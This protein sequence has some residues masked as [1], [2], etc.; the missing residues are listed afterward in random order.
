M[1]PISLASYYLKSYTLQSWLEFLIIVIQ[2]TIG[3][4]YITLLQ[5]SKY[6]AALGVMVMKFKIYD[7]TMNK[8]GF[9]RLSGRHWSTIMSVFTLW[10]TS[11]MI[12]WTKR[13]QGLHD[14]AART[15]CVKN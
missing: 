13:K 11:L 1:I 8:V 3:W 5:S 6:Q 7:E 2:C 4:L 10:V 12:G 9:W 14:M 15:I